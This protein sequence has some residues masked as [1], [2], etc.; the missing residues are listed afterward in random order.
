MEAALGSAQPPNFFLEEIGLYPF[1]FCIISPKHS[2]PLDR[3]LP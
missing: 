3:T 1:H 2:I